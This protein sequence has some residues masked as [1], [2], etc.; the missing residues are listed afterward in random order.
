MPRGIPNPKP[1]PP[2][3]ILGD[4][5]AS[6]E[7]VLNEVKV[8][9]ETRRTEY[10]SSAQRIADILDAMAPGPRIGRPRKEV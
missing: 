8:L 7:T 5:L 1:A 2:P 9:L 10:L 4:G 6:L 3:A